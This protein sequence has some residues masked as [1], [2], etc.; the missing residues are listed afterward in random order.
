MRDGTAAA[1]AGAALRTLGAIHDGGATSFRVWAPEHRSVDV[2]VYEDVGRA[3]HRLEQT[4][5]GY[6]SGTFDVPSGT[7]YKYRL[8]GDPRQTFP[9]PASRY[10]PEGVHGPS[11]I[12]DAQRFRWT[13]G[14]WIAP[15]L[16]GFVFYELHVGTFTPEGT[17]RGAIDR[18]PY[19]K[20]LGVTALEL[21]P[22]G[23][24]AGSRNWGYDGVTIFAPAHHYGTPDDLRA[25]VDAAHAHGLALF[26]DVVYNHFGPDG[27]YADL[28]SPYY[29]TDA[30][31]SPWGRGVNLDGPYASDVRRFLIE[32]AVHWVTEYH[33]DGLRLDATHALKDDS[34]RHFLAELT[35]TVREAAGRP[36]LF[37]AED[38]RNL[39]TLLLPVSQ[40]GYGL[41]AVWAD[42][43]HHGARVHTAHDSESY[44]GDFSGSTADLARTLR[45]GWL[46]T[47]QP[48][49]HEGGPRGTDPSALA[50]AQ[51]V[52]CVQ[53]HDQV[54]NRH[55]GARLHH[56]IDPAAYRA[57]A[58]LL[59]LAPETPLL[60][61]GQEWAASSPFQ[62]FTDHHEE[63]GRKVRTGRREE[64]RSFASFADP[65]RRALAPDPQDPGT[66]HRSRLRWDEIAAPAHA[67]VLR[68]FTRLLHIRRT[69]PALRDRTRESF[70][71]RTL[72]EH[73]LAL[74]YGGDALVV[75]ARL[76]GAAGIV[77]VAPQPRR[78]ALSTEDPAFVADPSPIVIDEERGVRFSRPGAVVLRGD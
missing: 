18:L 23:D 8:N 60:F 47:G 68:L 56:Q 6:W 29:F 77:D 65:A 31:E 39:A 76:S 37:V 24:F 12:V 69:H 13:D 22:V 17:F 33:V 46:F 25:L 63:L 35:T 41:D 50:P 72:D 27:A 73:T 16:G 20:A 1:P 38:H 64:F 45:Q 14:S 54:G 36:V 57:L 67:G 7:L 66:F 61:M 40:G 59:L 48:S 3:P 55:D 19:L 70:G 52:I 74:S 62:F 53:N 58:S 42:D 49:R 28:F 4:D 2:V 51:F 11:A 30:H 71:V 10:Q 32:N 9:D 78:M 15:R 5:P 44:Y 21:M 43:F 75:I 34:G 26:L